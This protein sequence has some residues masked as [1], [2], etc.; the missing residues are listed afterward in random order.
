M[1]WQ[2]NRVMYPVENLGPGRRLAIWVQ[3]CHLHCEGCISP[4]LWES[5][6][7]RKIDVA[8]FSAS[9]LRLAKNLD[10]ITITG[11]EPFNQYQQLVA[12]CSFVKQKTDLEILVFSGYTMD[13]LFKKFPDKLFTRCIDFVVDGPFVKSLHDHGNLRGSTN[14][15]MFTFDCTKEQ[16]KVQEL[17]V[18]PVNSPWSVEL[19]DSSAAFM[20]GIPGLNDTEKL[21]DKMKHSGI[22]FEI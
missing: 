3:G 5:E 18:P 19:D 7:G 8:G 2:L 6:G 16:V 14:Q 17:D 21:R 12:F 4:D 10:G 9:I 15:K 1:H 13:E 22:N 11:G 20:S